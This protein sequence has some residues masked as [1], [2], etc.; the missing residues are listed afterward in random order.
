MPVH[1]GDPG[2]FQKG[3][4]IEGPVDPSWTNMHPGKTVSKFPSGGKGK[5]TMLNSK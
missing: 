2:S 5:L 4:A 3:G 1:I